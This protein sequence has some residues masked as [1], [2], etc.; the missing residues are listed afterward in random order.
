VNGVPGNIF[1][2]RRGVIQGDPLSPLLFVLAAN[3]LQSIVNK[4][5]AEDILQLPINVG[6]TQDFPIIQYADNT[7][8]IMEACPR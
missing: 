8:L 1:H 2:C 3:L 6:Y 5:K 4:A 7:L